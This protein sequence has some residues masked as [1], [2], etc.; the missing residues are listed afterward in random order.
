MVIFLLDQGISA[1]V[2]T[3]V[4]AEDPCGSCA[5]HRETFF[6]VFH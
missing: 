2:Q 5:A 4:G 3:A 6:V 1:T